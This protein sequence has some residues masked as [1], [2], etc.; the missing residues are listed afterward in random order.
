MRVL[1]APIKQSFFDLKVILKIYFKPDLLVGI[2][3][4]KETLSQTGFQGCVIG[5]NKDNSC[6]YLWSFYIPRF[7][8]RGNKHSSQFCFTEHLL[9][10]FHVV[11]FS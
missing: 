7:A 3:G 8:S 9:K 2:V 6:R 1:A 5:F 11:K 10:L 4:I